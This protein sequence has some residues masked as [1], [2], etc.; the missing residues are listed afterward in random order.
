MYM[1]V[2]TSI[3][4]KFQTVIPAEIRKEFNLDKS[5]KIKW[6]IKDNGRIEL[7]FFK[8]L[9]LEDMIGRY[10]ADE[11]IDSVELKHDF[12]NNKLG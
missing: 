4:D 5:Y 7:E 9:S 1:V 10:S 6:E 12:K 3:Y 2:V 11:K 8:E